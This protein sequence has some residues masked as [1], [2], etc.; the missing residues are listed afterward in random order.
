MYE[1][2]FF[3][4]NLNLIKTIFKEK[5]MELIKI[6]ENIYEIEREGSMKVPARVFASEK[7]LEDI[8]KD[9]ALEQVKN[10]A[11]LPG[12]EKYA[13]MMPD[14]HQGYGFPIGGVAALS[15]R[16]GA[17]S[18]GGVGYD[19]NCGLKLLKTNLKSFEIEEKAEQLANILFNKIPLGLGK[20]GVKQFTSQK[21]FDEVLEK[22]SEWAV[23]NG[24][25]VKEDLDYCEENGKM[26]E[27][28]SS[29]ISSK[30]K[31]RGMKQLGS[32]GSGNHFLEV[33]RIDEIYDKETADRF[34]IF[35]DQVVITIHSGS[36]GLGHQVC[37]DYLRKIEKKHPEVLEDIPD[38]ELVFAPSNSKLADDYYKAMCGAANFAWAN[39][40]LLAHRVRECFEK[41]FKK[42]WKEMEMYSL[43]DVAHNIAKKEKHK[44]DEEEKEFFV[45]RKGATRAFPAEREEISEFFSETGQPVIIPGSMGTSSYILKGGEKSLEMTFG[46][47]A[48]GA[49]RLMSRT[50]AKKSFRGDRVQKDLKHRNIIVKARSG[51]NIA[52][53]APNVYKD[54]DEVIRV[55]DK[56]GI[57]KKVAKMVPMVNIKG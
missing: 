7:L 21:V 42:K 56:L 36:R 32:L 34:G 38:R 15:T 22:G 47:T 12:I 54:V 52:E 40:Q 46:S 1:K 6:S 10:I 45:H 35:K 11:H 20:G 9:R 16:N 37:S 13:I 2:V 18:P 41:I 19:I 55:S 29:K 23:K 33:Q 51:G 49:G 48:H 50:K 57:T 28:D 17:I 14:G 26:D 8:K 30:A 3:F 53:E 39:R 5:S 43:Y 27:A 31:Q 4:T 25:G 44:I 24:Y